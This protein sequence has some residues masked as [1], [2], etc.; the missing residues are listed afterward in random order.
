MVGGDEF[1][2]IYQIYINFNLIFF[3]KFLRICNNF[4]QS[5]RR[6]TPIHH[7][8]HAW[9]IVYHRMPHNDYV[10]LLLFICVSNVIQYHIPNITN[11]LHHSEGFVKTDHFYIHVTITHTTQILVDFYVVSIDNINNI[12]LFSGE[13]VTWT[14]PFHSVRPRTF[15]NNYFNLQLCSYVQA[16]IL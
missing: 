9:H 12:N 1:T 16:F 14:H 15:H 10:T 2:K 4:G 7:V 13:L 3:K 8:L 11:T 5:L 6:S